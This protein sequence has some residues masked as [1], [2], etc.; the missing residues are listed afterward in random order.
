MD[1]NKQIIL[2]GAER[3]AKQGSFDAARYFGLLDKSLEPKLLTVIVPMRDGGNNLV[4]FGGDAKIEPSDLQ[5]LYN[6]MS[7]FPRWHHENLAPDVQGLVWQAR[8]DAKKALQA[9][10]ESGLTATDRIDF[11]SLPLFSQDLCVFALL[12][13][14]R[15]KIKSFYSIPGPTYGGLPIGI[16]LISESIS[17][18]MHKASSAL[19]S[20]ARGHAGTILGADYDEQFRSAGFWLMDVV[21]KAAKT[22][23]NSVS[24]DNAFR[25]LNEIAASYYEKKESHGILLFARAATKRSE[26]SLDSD[27]RFAWS[28]IDRFG[29]SWSCQPMGSHSWQILPSY[30]ASAS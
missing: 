29:S 27:R 19:E 3:L 7:L 9:V 20:L 18:F 13:L 22:Q 15:S 6:A 17:A 4:V 16:S 8:V 23:D 24:T 25:H 14:N 2:N 21:E 30:M 1:L 26:K 28:F 10:I 12:E 5:D 11:V